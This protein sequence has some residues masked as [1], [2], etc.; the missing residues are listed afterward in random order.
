MKFITIK[1]D[2]SRDGSK[3]KKWMGKPLKPNFQLA[4]DYINKMV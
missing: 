3:K 4:E 2:R 1:S